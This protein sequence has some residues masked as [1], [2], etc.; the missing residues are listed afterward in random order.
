[1]IDCD[2]VVVG[3]TTAGCVLAKRLSEDPVASMNLA[4]GRF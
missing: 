2:F 1:M 4:R 3:G